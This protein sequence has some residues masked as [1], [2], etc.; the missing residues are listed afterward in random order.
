MG[1]FKRILNMRVIFVDTNDSHGVAVQ[2]IV[3]VQAAY[4]RGKK[5]Y[6]CLLLFS[7]IINDISR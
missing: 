3:N 1:H 7:P 5:L 6:K 2:R 4:L